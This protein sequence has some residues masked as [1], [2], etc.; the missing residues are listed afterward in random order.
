MF[1][2]WHLEHSVI[3]YERAER[4]LEVFRI[5]CLQP[6]DIADVGCYRGAFSS[7]FCRFAAYHA[8]DK[9]VHCFDT[10]AGLPEFGKHD[11]SEA[12]GDQRYAADLDEVLT[13]LT[14]Y[15]NAHVYAGN[16]AN[17]TLDAKLCFALV[18]LDLY[19]S[20]RDALHLVMPQVVPR[21]WL[22][23]DDYGAELWWPGV[24][25]AVDEVLDE[26]DW[27]IWHL[28]ELFLCVARKLP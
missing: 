5:A 22:V 15:D 23:I 17:F 20:T 16:V 1:W 11:N 26:S 8:L 4:V 19:Q 2:E 10:F 6:G 3:S 27:D 14:P 21:G 7:E 13:K 12:T 25:R 28:P 18:D 24:R 9:Q